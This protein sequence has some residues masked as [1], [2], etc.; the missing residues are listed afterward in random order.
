MNSTKGER[1]FNVLKSL[2][3]CFNEVDEAC[4]EASE[5][6]NLY[7]PT[8]RPEIRDVVYKELEQYGFEYIARN[9]FRKT[10]TWKN[11]LK[12]YLPPVVVNIL[13]NRK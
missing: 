8:K 9:Y 13:R 1:I 10:Q 5:N 3:V 4:V 12:N 2:G 11:K 6:K 7:C